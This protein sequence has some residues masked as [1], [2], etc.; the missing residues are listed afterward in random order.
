MMIFVLI[1]LCNLISKDKTIVKKYYFILILFIKWGKW[2]E[3]CVCMACTCVC[4][5]VFIVNVC[6][7][8]CSHKDK[9]M[10]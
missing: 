6:D 5:C 3:M 1:Y 9:I 10:S 7:A 8:K 4:V 2:F